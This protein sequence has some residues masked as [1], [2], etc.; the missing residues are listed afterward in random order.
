MKLKVIGYW[1]GFPAANEATSGYLLESNG[2]KLLVD[3]GS[4]VLSKLQETI[5]ID[6]LDAVIL[7]HYHHD[8][9][10]DIGPLQYAN[11]VTSM[12]KGTKKTLPIYGHALDMQAFNRLTYK[13]ATKGIVYDP[14]KSLMIGPFT[15]TFLRTIHPAPCF[16]MRI[17]DQKSTIVYTADSSFQEAFIPFST[18]ADLLIAESNFYADQDGT[19]AGH[20]NSKE[21]AHIAEAANVKQLL[22]THLPHFGEHDNLVKEASEDFKG[23]VVLASSGYEWNND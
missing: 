7:S 18:G 15:L 1:G 20:M 2:Y 16:A 6:E 17:T 12:L 9:I 14:H 23:Q 19:N 21:A 3:C 11:Y 22:L 5:S 4:A 10:A 8:H 13:D